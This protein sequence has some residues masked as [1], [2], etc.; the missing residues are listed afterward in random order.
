MLK[1]MCVCVS[2]RRTWRMPRKLPKIGWKKNQNVQDW[3][4]WQF[5]WLI[6][7]LLV[8]KI[9]FKEEKSKLDV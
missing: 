5:N 4:M 9:Q 7:A 1:K 8:K 6:K 3:K 2:V